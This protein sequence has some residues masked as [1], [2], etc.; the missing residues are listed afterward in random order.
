MGL[1]YD[2][3]RPAGGAAGAGKGIPLRPL[4]ELAGLRALE[5]AAKFC[6]VMTCRAPVHYE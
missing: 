2:L 5:A 6:L 1:L 3:I 4:L